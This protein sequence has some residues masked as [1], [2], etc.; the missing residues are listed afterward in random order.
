MAAWWRSG[1]ACRQGGTNKAQTGSSSNDS[2]FFLQAGSDDR[3][4]LWV[5]AGSGEA[6]LQAIR[7]SNILSDRPV[8]V[9]V[10][11]FGT[12]F[13]VATIAWTMAAAFILGCLNA[14]SCGC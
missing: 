14:M 8:D 12:P 6:N 7:A 9:R 5:G 10:S 2:V 1:R 3:L 4:K 13:R 11:G